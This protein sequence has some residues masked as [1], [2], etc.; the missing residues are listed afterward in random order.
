VR[1]VAAVVDVVRHHVLAGELDHLLYVL[2][3]KI[4]AVV[5][6]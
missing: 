2:P 3:G 4:R 6:S 1:T 5:A